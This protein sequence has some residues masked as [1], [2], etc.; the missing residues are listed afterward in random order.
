[1][2]AHENPME[3]YGCLYK[4]LGLFGDAVH[5]ARVQGLELGCSRI[6]RELRSME[7]HTMISSG[8]AVQ[9]PGSWSLGLRAWPGIGCQFSFF[10]H[11]PKPGLWSLRVELKVVPLLYAYILR[12]L[13]I[14]TIEL[15]RFANVYNM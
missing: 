15:Y 10:A 1:M 9:G 4:S 14:Y 13:C 7:A 12:N 3:A 11:T 6:P 2:E 8:G 5:Q